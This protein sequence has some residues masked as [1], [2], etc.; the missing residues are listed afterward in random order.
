MDDAS[1][2]DGERPTKAVSLQV[3]DHRREIGRK[4]VPGS[5][6][7][8]AYGKTA[9]RIDAGA[10]IDRRRRDAAAFDEGREL[11]DGVP[12]RRT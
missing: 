12:R 11:T 4:L 2:G 6:T 9:D 1:V 5:R 10:Q 3:A 7:A 8:A